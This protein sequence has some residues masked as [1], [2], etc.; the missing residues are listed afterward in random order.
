MAM[1]RITSLWV[2]LA[3]LL[4]VACSNPSIQPGTNKYGAGALERAMADYVTEYPGRTREELRQNDKVVGEV[5]RLIRQGADV[6][7]QRPDRGDTPLHIAVLYKAPDLVRVLVNA[8]ARLDIEETARGGLTPLEYAQW[9][10]QRNPERDYSAV[11][12]ILE[13]AKRERQ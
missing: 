7:Y 10:Q 2:V 1:L 5:K 9:L 13:Q 3:A 4:L 8:G 11:I 6:N 12:R